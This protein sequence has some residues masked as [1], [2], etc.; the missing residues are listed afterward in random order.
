MDTEIYTTPIAVTSQFS[1]CG[2]PLRLDTYRGCGFQCSFCFARQRGG[3]SPET[4]ILPANPKAIRAQIERAFASDPDKLGII[5]QFLRRRVPIHFGGM[6]DPFQPVEARFGVTKET[7]ALLAEF[8]YPTVISTR[9][10]MASSSPYRDLLRQL[11][12]VV[13]QFSMSSSRDQIAHVLEPRS[14]AP[15]RLLKCMQTLATD[16]IPVTCRWQPYVPGCSEEPS[17][18]ASRLSDA[19]CAHVGF[20][21]LKV[22]LERHSSHWQDFVRQIGHDMHTEYKAAGAYRDG[23]ELIMPAKRKLDVVLKTAAE[24]RRRG[25][26]FGAADNEFQYY[27]DSSCCCSGVDRFPGFENYFKH[28]IGYALRKCRGQLI[29][30]ESIKGEWAPQGSI[31]RYLNSRSRIGSRNGEQSTIIDHIRLRW[32]QT[33]GPGSPSSFFGV[34]VGQSKIHGMNTYVWSEESLRRPDPDEH[35]K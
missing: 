21:H 27:S 9:G 28:Q 7:L 10:A 22:P 24:V 11:K 25:M 6:S 2:L 20:E 33:S 5:G 35:Q 30:Y 4:S 18:F 34:K 23:R 8:D 3:N 13:V 14:T 17:E 16:G 31:D 26:S 12:F 29:T 19:G 15:S 32:N 1:F